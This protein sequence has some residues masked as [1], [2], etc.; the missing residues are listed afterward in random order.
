MVGRNMGLL[1]L[2]RSN[3]LR[4]YFSAL[5]APLTLALGA[6]VMSSGACVPQSLGL[7]VHHANGV[8]PQP[9]GGDPVAISPLKRDDLGRHKPGYAVLRST[10]DWDL[11]FADPAIRPIGIDFSQTMVIAAYADDSTLSGIQIK[12]VMDGG[13]TLNVFVTEIAP[14]DGCPARQNQPPSALVT[15]DRHLES[16]AVYVDTERGPRC[17]ADPPQI[18]VTCRVPPAKEWTENLSAPIGQKVECAAALDMSQQ[19]RTIVDRD[20]SIRELPR[21]SDARISLIDEAHKASF[22]VD[23]LGTYRL[24][25]AA[26]DEAARVGE[27]I[28]KID[29]PPPS[30]DFYAELVWSNFTSSDDPDTFP[31]IELRAKEPLGRDLNI[32]PVVVAK[33]PPSKAAL[34]QGQL[35]A[36]A[37]SNH[38]TICSIEIADHPTWCEAW[39]YGKNTVMR[40]RGASG[41]RYDISVHYTDDRF[42]GAPVACVRTFAKGKLAFEVCDNQVRKADSSW[43]IGAIVESTGRFDVPDEIPVTSADGGAPLSA[44][45]AGAALVRSPDAGK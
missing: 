3:S 10:D 32:K 4:A 39:K 27:A 45:D 34:I 40:L 19:R 22:T 18:K 38:S 35:H 36:P 21:G 24:R 6:A 31:R 29:V 8:D 37:G 5:S 30:D 26:T 15:V 41:G 11:F 7:T 14:G 20:W 9:E 2:S 44:G 17:E 13:D 12:K 16:I 28:A 43:D 23:A 33:G 1:S 25:V 42:A